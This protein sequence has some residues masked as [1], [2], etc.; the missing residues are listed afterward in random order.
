MLF[1]TKNITTILLIA[2]AVLVTLQLKSCF[3]GGKKPP[4][5]SGEIKAKD[6]LI[7]MITNDR[8]YHRNRADSAISVLVTQDNSKVKEIQTIIYERDKVPDRVRS[9][10][11]DSLYAT[12]IGR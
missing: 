3:D 11:R 12:A 7:E 9:L 5:I 6:D 1:I 8:D 4:D 10:S 2:M